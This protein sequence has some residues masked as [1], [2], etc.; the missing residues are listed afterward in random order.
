M[1]QMQNESDNK[2]VYDDD[3]EK[4]TDSSSSSSSSNN[5]SGNS[6]GKNDVEDIGGIS[7][8]EAVYIVKKEASLLPDLL[9]IAP[10]FAKAF[11]SDGMTLLHEAS[12]TGNTESITILLDYL[13]DDVAEINRR[14]D[15]NGGNAMWLAKKGGHDEVVK[16]LEAHGGIELLPIHNSEL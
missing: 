8:E 2:K 3:G 12:A 7:F 14:I 13:N 6:N 9:S 5:S 16:L 11:G 1:K 15:G 4:K 10:K